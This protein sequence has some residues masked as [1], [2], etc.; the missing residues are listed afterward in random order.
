ME[1]E[2][3]PLYI[4]ACYYDWW[5]RKIWTDRGVRRNGRAY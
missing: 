5:E 4:Q 3:G 1:T 2:V